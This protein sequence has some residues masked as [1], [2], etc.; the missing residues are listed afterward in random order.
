[1]AAFNSA[2]SGLRFHQVMGDTMDPTIRRLDYVLVAPA[3]RYVG[4]GLYLMSDPVDGG[5]AVYSCSA[6][7]R[8]IIRLHCHNK[9][10]ADQLIPRRDFEERV[11]AEVVMT[12]NVIRHDVLARVSLRQKTEA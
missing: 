8:R 3:H 6:G 9:H 4:E 10:Y 12:C 11:L 2:G 7:E 5:A 1:M